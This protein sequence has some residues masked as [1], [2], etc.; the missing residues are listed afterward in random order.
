M[1][2][3]VPKQYLML[4]D[5][6]V[7]YYALYTLQNSFIDEII[8]VTAPGEEKYC[9]KEIKDK[10]NFDKITKIVAGGQERY[11]SVYN[12]LCA[13][14]DVDY[15]FIHDGARPF[16]SADILDR[17]LETVKSAN[18]CVTAVPVTDTIKLVDDNGYV[19]DTPDRAHLWSMQTP[20][21]FKYSL[22][23]EAYDILI[24]KEAF[25]TEK[26]IRITDDAM[27]AESVMHMPVKIVEGS[28]DNIKIT[29][30][31]DLAK[32]EIICKQRKNG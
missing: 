6:P 20:Q 7:L 18:A 27:V 26:G 11:H 4:E 13:L 31:T 28:Y 16:L 15:V 29:T 24:D 12:G 30:P 25:Y 9:S 10:Y 1:N 23:K 5:K 17:L 14:Q 21:T 8:L 2:S 32:A 3:K 22:I 19:V